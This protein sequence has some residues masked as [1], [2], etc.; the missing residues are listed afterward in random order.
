VY[1]LH[2]S[3]LTPQALRADILNGSATDDCFPWILQARPR[4]ACLM[5]SGER[6][7][8]L[9]RHGYGRADFL[10]GP[11]LQIGALSFKPGP[12]LVPTN[13]GRGPLCVK[14]LLAG[15]Q[16]FGLRN[17]LNH[18]KITRKIG[19]LPPQNM[20]HVQE[21]LR[22]ARLGLLIPPQENPVHPR[23]LGVCSGILSFHA[24]K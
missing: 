8:N 20:H 15:R 1:D 4:D 14:L 12:D 7:L 11:A 21:L 2:A 3:L 10:F 19:T 24:L 5:R 17:R 22:V 18:N 9:A 13:V 16:A 6:R 23:R